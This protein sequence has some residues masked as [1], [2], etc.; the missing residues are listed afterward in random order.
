[1]QALGTSGSHVHFLDPFIIPAP[2]C[3]ETRLCVRKS[4]T[5]LS[6]GGKYYLDRF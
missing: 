4:A 1:M 5:A 2:V 3:S 6:A